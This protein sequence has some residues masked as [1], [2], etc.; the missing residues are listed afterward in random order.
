MQQL[1][2]GKGKIVLITIEVF[3]K[4]GPLRKYL[5]EK[6]TVPAA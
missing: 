6:Q 5:A 2:S 1:F 3:S 4:R